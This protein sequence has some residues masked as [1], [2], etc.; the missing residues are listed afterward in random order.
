MVPLSSPQSFSTV[1]QPQQQQQQ[2]QHCPT[3][4]NVWRSRDNI[5]SPL[6]QQQQQQQHNNNNNNILQFN[7]VQRLNEKYNSSN[8]GRGLGFMKSR[9]YSASSEMVNSPTANNNNN[10]NNSV[11]YLV[12]PPPHYPS[13]LKRFS[14]FFTQTN[15][16]QQ[17]QQQPIHTHKSLENLD[18]SSNH[19]FGGS[20]PVHSS[21]APVPFSHQK[22]RRPLYS[23]NNPY[24]ATNKDESGFTGVP[25]SRGCV[26]LRPEQNIPDVFSTA[27]KPINENNMCKA[28]D[29]DEDDDKPNGGDSNTGENQNSGDPTTIS[30]DDIVVTMRSVNV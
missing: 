25:V 1:Q 9:F 14:P 27:F 16:Q 4:N 24:S 29:D 21:G 3:T 12:S 23:H 26:Y 22:R 18:G 30:R 20:T 17:L 5:S 13:Q 7:T 8:P 10:S 2:Q 11:N 19:N 28:D 15:Q 6:H